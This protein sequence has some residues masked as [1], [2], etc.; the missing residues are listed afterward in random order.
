GHFR[1]AGP[2]GDGGTE[3]HCPSCD[4]CSR[5]TDE[6]TGRANCD[7]D[8]GYKHSA[9]ADLSPFNE[10]TAASPDFHAIANGNPI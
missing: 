7:C 4:E 6:H 1:T 8:P 10:Y 3:Q 9:A 2:R 5:P